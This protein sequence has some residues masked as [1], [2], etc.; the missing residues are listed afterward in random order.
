MRHPFFPAVALIL[1]LAAPAAPAQRR[2]AATRP[3]PVQHRPAATR[4]V[5]VPPAEILTA[6]QRADV[7]AEL[8]R[9]LRGAAVDPASVASHQLRP[10][11]LNDVESDEAPPR[12]GSM[13]PAA[14]TRRMDAATAQAVLAEAGP[15][16]MVR[17]SPTLR[18]VDG[19][20]LD[21][22]GFTAALH[23]ALKDNVAGYVMELRQHGETI[24]RLQWSWGRRPSDG[25]VGWTPERRMHVASVSKL[26][27]SM[28]LVRLL[29]ERGI[30]FDT[31]IHSYLPRYWQ[32]GSN[33]D[34]ITFAQLLTHR[35]GFRVP[36]GS[37][38][39][40]TMRQRVEA[41]V[42]DTAVGAKQYQN[43]NF[44]LMRL[45]IP[46]ISGE[47][48]RGL[49]REMAPADGHLS[50]VDYLWDAVTTERYHDFVASRVFAPAGVPASVGFTHGPNSALAYRFPVSG[51]AWDSGD[52]RSVSGGAGWVISADELLDVMGEY[53][54]GGGIVPAGRA[55]QALD[56]GFG[57]DVVADTPAGRLY[58]KNGR[59]QNNGR[60]EQS[61]AYF[62][63]E[64][65]ELVVLT[66]S[67]VGSQDVFFR[68]VV[69]EIYRNNLR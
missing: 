1:A 54:R 19:P 35:S 13:V 47:V 62:L 69:T 52:L 32:R 55:M 16:G 17:A 63:P 48:D 64:D 10:V 34:R 51:E 30:A 45:L 21:V 41:G 50:W 60:T 2:P 44:G 49:L 6:L 4:P 65:M 25:G 14:I 66:N 15:A 61:L 3:A 56:S 33:I 29:N 26:I 9:G 42:A 8:T 18:A 40:W 31:P 53:R 23:Q 36:D 5:P 20:S 28:A 37:T 38:D 67:A 68:G 57:V 39:Y 27:T 58:N 43:M 7:R 46:I 59:W 12:R 24:A 22:A 11:N